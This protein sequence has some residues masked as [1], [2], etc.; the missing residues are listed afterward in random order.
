MKF[1][2]DLQ[3]ICPNGVVINRKL[4]ESALNGWPE[5]K[6]GCR[7]CTW[8]STSRPCLSTGPPRLLSSDDLLGFCS[9]FFATFLDYKVNYVKFDTSTASRCLSVFLYIKLYHKFTKLILDIQTVSREELEPGFSLLVRTLP[10]ADWA[11]RFLDRDRL[12]FSNRSWK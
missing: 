11:Y 3:C 6:L 12:R 1:G 4:W 9:E 10:K 7:I 5:S 2:T 8:F